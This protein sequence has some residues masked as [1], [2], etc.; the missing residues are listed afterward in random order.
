M[1]FIDNIGIEQRQH[2]QTTGF[3]IG[4]CHRRGGR[5]RPDADGSLEGESRFRVTLELAKRDFLE[6]T[7]RRM[8]WLHGVRNAYR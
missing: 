5:F 1:K 3:F 2:G 6:H 4:N 8:L 7:P